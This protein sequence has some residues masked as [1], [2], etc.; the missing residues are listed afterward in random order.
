MTSIGVGI[1][2]H[3]SSLTSINIP[4]SVTSINSYAFYD[5]TGLTSVTI[6]NLVTN[7]K[8][9]AF[10]GCTNLSSII[11]PNSVTSIGAHAFD[12]TPWYNNQPDGLIYVSKVAYKYKGTMP[13]NTSI[14]IEEGTVGIAE[15]AFEQCSR[16]ISINIPN[17]VTNIGKS[18]FAGTGLTSI[19]IPNSV[20][21]ISSG[22]LYVC[23]NLR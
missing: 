11:V 17:S 12:G 20:T 7:I 23:S 8:D 10:S 21:T 16:L 6:P 3:C 1:F 5:C 2:S 9:Y 22:L 14:I 4:N 13:E 19:N 15:E 18:A